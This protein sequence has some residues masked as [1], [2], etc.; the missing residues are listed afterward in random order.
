MLP[1]QPLQQTNFVDGIKF[2][3]QQIQ[4]SNDYVNQKLSLT[5]IYG[6][7][8]GVLVG[9]LNSMALKIEED[10]LILQ[11]GAAIDEHGNIILA[12]RD[13]IVSEDILTEKYENRT[14]NYVYL[15]HESKMDDL[16]ASRHDKDVKLYYSIKESFQIILSD[17]LIKNQPVIE[18]GRFYVNKKSSSKIKMPLNPFEADDNEIDLGYVPKVLGMNVS[19]SKNERFLI[20]NAMY[21]YGAFLHEFGLRKSIHSMATVASFAFTLSNDI[22]NR[23]T[24]GVWHLYNMLQDLLKISLHIEIERE[25]IVN[26]ALWKNL[27]RL[28]SI[29]AFKESLRVDYYNLL[30]SIDSSFFSKVILHFNNATIFDGDWDNILQEKKEEKVVKNYL[31]VGSD[32]ACDMLVEGEDVAPKHAKIY[33][34]ETGYFIE[35][36]QDTSGVYVNAERIDKGTKK[37]IR[38]QDYVVLGKNGRVLNLQNIQL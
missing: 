33:K 18:V 34:Y 38:K 9:F 12:E 19:I 23:G 21:K 32:P 35:D 26:T 14:T 29:F 5:N 31:I 6:V 10:K 36:L 28:E 24:V 3:P 15:L 13:Y 1:S 11:S 25:D 17:K 7:G 30:L 37:F 8:K 20:A 27:V 16:N 22:K 2:N 4:V